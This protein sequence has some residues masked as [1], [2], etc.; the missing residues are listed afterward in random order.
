LGVSNFVAS[1]SVHPKSMGCKSGG[2]LSKALNQIAVWMCPL[3]A[4][5]PNASVVA[6]MV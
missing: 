5:S 6:G 2:S 1:T 3:F 4:F